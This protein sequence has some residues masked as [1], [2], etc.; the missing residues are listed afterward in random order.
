MP[1]TSMNLESGRSAHC[2]VSVLPKAKLLGIALQDQKKKK[3]VCT[4]RT[5]V[6]SIQYIQIFASSHLQKI[7]Y[8]MNLGARPPLLVLTVPIAEIMNIT[9]A[10]SSTSATRGKLDPTAAT[11]I[12]PWKGCMDWRAFDIT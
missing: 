11:I 8:Q 9:R 6:C 3:K 2:S 7:F 4:V 1:L 12:R 5:V 10:S